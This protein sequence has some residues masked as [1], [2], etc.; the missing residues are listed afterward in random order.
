MLDGNETHLVSSLCL[1]LAHPHPESRAVLAR[2]FRRLGWDVYLAHSGAEARRLARMLEADMVILHIDLPEESGW[3]T[4]DKLTRE[5]PMAC[6]VLVSDNLS[7]QDQ[8]LAGFVGAKALVNRA[9]GVVPLVE[10][11]LDPALPAAG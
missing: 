11:L 1:V 10:D 3:L 8:E 6:V 9:D 7:A 5:L 2:N 4:C